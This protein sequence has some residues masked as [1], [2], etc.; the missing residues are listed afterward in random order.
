MTVSKAGVLN[1][2]SIRSSGTST[3][4]ITVASGAHH[5]RFVGVRVTTSAPVTN[6]LVRIGLAET[7][8]A[9]LPHH[10][11][12]DRVV[13]D[14]GANDLR[15][16]VAADGAYL[17]VLSST[18]ANCHSNQGDS[19]GILS[20]N[21]RGPLRIENNTIQGGHQ[22]IMF[23]G[24]DPVIVGQVPSDIVI[25]RNDLSRPL[26]WRRAVAGVYN[27]G[28]WQ[29]KTGVEFKIGKRA[30]IEAN[31]LCHTWADAQTGHA[32]L[33]KT[34]NQN[35]SAPWS[36]TSDITVRYNR[37]CG[38]SAGFNLAPLP[39]G[40]GVPFSRA[41][42]YNNELDSISVGPFASE[43]GECLLLQGV[44]DVVYKDNWCRNPT[45]R[46]AIYAA[47]TSARFVAINDAFG[48]E[49]GLKGDAVAF[50]TWVPGSIVSNNTL[51]PFGT[52]FSAWPAT[53]ADSTRSALLNGVMVAP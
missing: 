21:A 44:A 23:G 9:Q 13:V 30:L 49:Y 52:A 26:S 3:P 46:A 17:A 38:A 2:A 14:P 27:A 6:A 39:A 42:I 19:Q 11:T 22:A 32:F 8:V 1:L 10:I 34:E 36:E 25:R 12:L 28:E 29:G 47:G 20:I 33:L 18:L 37:V 24:G 16:C 31:V 48:G 5:V 45:G 53:P 7:S 41:T 43:T 15:R 4:A 40:P 50:S 35:G 51:V